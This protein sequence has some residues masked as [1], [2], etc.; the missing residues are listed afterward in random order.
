MSADAIVYLAR[1]LLLHPDE[2]EDNPDKREGLSYGNKATRDAYAAFVLEL[3]DDK[4]D[5]ADKSGCGWVCEG[6]LRKSEVD[7]RIRWRTVPEVDMLRTPYAK[8]WPAGYSCPAIVYQRELGRQRRLRTDTVKWTPDGPLPDPAAM[9]TIGGDPPQSQ[10]PANYQPQWGGIAHVE[11][12]VRRDGRR[13]WSVAGGQ[14]D[15]DNQ[16]LP[17]AIR[18]VERVLVWVG[19]RRELWACRPGTPEEL[20]DRP[21]WGTG[22]RVQDWTDAG[23][24]PTLPPSL[25]GPRSAA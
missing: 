6:V 2:A 22:R 1:S 8:R 12:V 23:A 18:L 7:G 13:I 16:G 4:S 5:A 20:A 14:T 3:D 24:L 10:W 9:I 11:T 17:T 19:K 15:H 21:P 25:T